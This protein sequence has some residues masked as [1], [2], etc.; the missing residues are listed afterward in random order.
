MIRSVLDFFMPLFAFYCLFMAVQHPILAILAILALITFFVIWTV[1]DA[2]FS[3][4]DFAVR[5]IN[6]IDKS[7]D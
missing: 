4:S 1:I 2:V 6:H 5:I 3:I 7:I